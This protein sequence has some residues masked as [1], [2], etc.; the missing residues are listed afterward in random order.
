VATAVVTAVASVAAAV[1]VAAVAVAGVAG[2]HPDRNRS[3]I[4]ISELPSGIRLV[5]ERMPE[6]RS[7]AIGAYVGVGG[8]DEPD[9]VAGASHFLEHLLFKGTSMRSAR[10]IA[11]RIDA[12]GGDMNAYTSREHTAFYARVPG[13]DRAETLALLLDVLAQPALRPHEV[14][15]EREVILEELAAAED[16]PEDVVHM[17]LAEALYP[18]HPLGREVLGTEESIAA[19]PRADI[20]A[21]HDRWYRPANVVVALAGDVDHDEACAALDGF[22]AA[23]PGGER[24]VRVAPDAAPVAEV[25][26]RLPIEQAHLAAGWW[27]GGHDDPDRYPL[28]FANYVLGGGTASRLFQQ[29]REERGLAYT[30]FSSVSLNV[31]RGSLT[32]YAATS[33]AKLAE[34][35]SIVDDQVGSLVEHGI[36]EAE[37]ALALGYLEGSLLLN[38]EDAGSR[39]GRLGRGL[40]ARGVVDSVDEHVAQLRSVSV[41][42]VHR[43]LRRMLSGPRSLAAVGPFDKLP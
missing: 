11:E 41:D 2:N 17:R 16:N 30:V 5:S 32:I 37:H 7:A 9:P 42:D 13:R 3:L 22:V 24:P 38:L 21:F 20:A 10:E 8:R 14:D 26:E 1:A 23:G 39:M 27:V 31:D 25:V 4:R 35:L 6:A 33:P 43:V 29:V 19:M 15:A 40:L 18:G 36:T 12:T 28:A 34:V